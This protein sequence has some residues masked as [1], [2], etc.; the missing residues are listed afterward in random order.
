MPLGYQELNLNEGKVWSL[1]GVK[2]RV[3]SLV[4]GELTTEPASNERKTL[5]MCVA[6]GEHVSCEDGDRLV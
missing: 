6:S 3:I 1:Y 2:M 4:T 5:T